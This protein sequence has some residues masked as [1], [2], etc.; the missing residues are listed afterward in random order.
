MTASKIIRARRRVLGFAL[1]LTV[2]TG[3]GVL[4]TRAWRETQLRDAYLPELQEQALHHPG[5]GRLLALLG[6]RQLEA[7]DYGSAQSTLQRAIQAG[8]ARPS[9][10]MAWAASSAALGDRAKTGNILQTALHSE[11]EAEAKEALDRCRLLPP[12]AG[13]GQIAGAVSPQGITPLLADYAQGSSLNGLSDR[14]NR[15]HPERSGFAYRESQARLHPQDAQAQRLWGLALLRN[16]RTSE[17]LPVLQNA[18]ALAPNSPATHLALGSA[19]EQAGATAKAGL[20]YRAV[21]RT[22]VNAL[23]AQLGLGRVAAAKNLIKLAVQTYEAA[24][25]SHPESAEAWI[26]LGLAYYNGGFQFANSVAA[27]EKAVSLAPSRTDFYCDYCNALRK[28]FQLDVSE[29]TI[30]KR[31]TAAPDDARAHYLLALLLQDNRPDPQRT[32][33]SEQELRAALRYA[34]HSAAANTK[35]AQLLQAQNKP[36]EAIPLLVDAVN[37]DPDNPQILSLL[38]RALQATGQ[39]ANAKRL[40][41]RVG[42][43]ARR[44][45]RRLFLEDREHRQPADIQT[46]LDLANFYA[47]DGQNAKAAQEREMASLL[48]SHPGEVAK[49]LTTLDKATTVN[50]PASP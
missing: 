44:N 43:L 7:H 14:W 47:Q 25:R 29:A 45:E 50:S 34:P 42:M 19:L 5:E 23:P 6:A 1:T 17:S 40:F 21:L 2:L 38:A 16:R 48:Q 31:L 39:A 9:V 13:L 36:S 10:W 28:D 32:L 26:G 49:G 15:A 33:T 27:F 37:A 8:A 4:F 18:V 12:D 41:A 46:H 20:E 22:D 24:T 30:R 35:L 11:A 3:G